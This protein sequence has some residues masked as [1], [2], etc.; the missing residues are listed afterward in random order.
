[1]HPDKHISAGSIYDEAPP[2]ATFCLARDG[3]PLPSGSVCKTTLAMSSCMI[4]TTA[5]VGHYCPLCGSRHDRDD[6]DHCELVAL[7]HGEEPAWHKLEGIHLSNEGD[8]RV[9]HDRTAA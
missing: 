3:D 5:D 9:R 4:D 1:M 7:C 2:R 8:H 6:V